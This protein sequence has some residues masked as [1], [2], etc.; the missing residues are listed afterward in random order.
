MTNFQT[1]LFKCSYRYNIIP[2]LSGVTCFKK[3]QYIQKDQNNSN[4]DRI[5]G[6]LINYLGS[7][8]SNSS[9]NYS[10]SSSDNSYSSSSQS[11]S[12]TSGDFGGGNNNDGGGAGGSF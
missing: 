3:F 6:S 9:S 4:N 10:Y 1:S 8:S 5:S 12:S 2:N 11:S 7:D